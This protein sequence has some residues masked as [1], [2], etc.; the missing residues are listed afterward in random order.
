MKLLSS[1]TLL[2]YFNDYLIDSGVIEHDFIDKRSSKHKVYY[3]ET[4]DKLKGRPISYPGF[5]KYL[6]LVKKFC[7]KS[8]NDARQL[9]VEDNDLLKLIKSVC[10]GELVDLSLLSVV[11]SQ[12]A[13]FVLKNKHG[14]DVSKTE[15]D[16]ES[17]KA[18]T[19]IIIGKLDVSS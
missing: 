4:V 5:F 11:N 17:S 14:Y 6:V 3:K 1:E 2:E 16:S 19:Q 9:L 12:T 8:L 18:P 13:H 15:D 7:P 10:E